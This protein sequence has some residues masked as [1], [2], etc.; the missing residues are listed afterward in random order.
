MPNNDIARQSSFLKKH[1]LK[2][3]AAIFFILCFL[4]GFDHLVSFIASIVLLGLVI[5]FSYK[6]LKEV[7]I[8]S[9]LILLIPILSY[10]VI[11]AL[12]YFSNALYPVLTRV[13]LTFTLLI[14]AI[15]GYLSRNIKEFDF[16][17]IFVGIYVA[18]AII[19]LINLISTLVNFGPFHALRLEDYYSY[20]A[21]TQ[22]ET[23]VRASAYA[24][25]GFNIREVTIE[26]YLF[27]PFMLLSS[28]LFYLLGNKKNLFNIISNG[29]F[30][31]IALL[32]LLFVISKLSITFIAIYLVVL[33]A[34][35]LLISYKG[36]FQKMRI[37]F[38]VL[39]GL[40]AIFF[41]IFFIVS[42]NPVEKLDFI[43]S[44]Q[45]LNYIFITNRYSSNMR[46]LLYKVISMDKL[47]GFP[48]YLDYET[49]KY[50]YPSNNIVVNQLMYGG[51]FGFIF[52]ILIIALSFYT[53]HKVNKLDIDDKVYKYMPL[54]F[55]FIYLVS[56]FLVEPNTPD[57][58]ISFHQDRLVPSFLSSF[59]YMAL[60]FLAHYFN[61]INMKEV[62]ENEK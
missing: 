55:A 49:F 9:L 54:L 18:L 58:F 30:V 53:F 12:G 61:L 27:F 5:I 35:G 7:N 4:T 22:A 57:R 3:F 17:S 59:M 21:G 31:F 20:Y 44:N 6:N 14:F 60:F 29:V 8:Y 45:I 47:I 62:K 33:I 28:G 16:K 34:I 15:S 51:L 25:S 1:S 13:L 43:T 37:P 40:I 42:Q 46:G 52:F 56:A 11:C 41:I 39:I 48:P 50:V 32:S 10:G 26:Y 24:L 2:V 19:C 36:M 23:T 38:Y